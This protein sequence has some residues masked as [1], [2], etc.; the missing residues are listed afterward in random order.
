VVDSQIQP[1]TTSDA[2]PSKRDELLEAAE[3]LFSDRGFANT[4][5]SEIAAAAG[6]GISTFYRYFPTKDALLGARIAERF[7]QL[8]NE[9]TQARENIENRPAAEQVE[10]T[11]ETFGIGFDA[12]VERPRLTQMVFTSGFGSSKEVR[13]LVLGLQASAAADLE[14]VL[15]RV[16]AASGLRIPAKLALAQAAVGGLLHLAYA[17]ITEGRPKRDDAI[18]ALSSMLIGA[19]A[20]A[21]P[22]WANEAK[23]PGV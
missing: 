22:Q 4:R 8:R 17:H 16:E 10:V 2:A 23:E 18:H 6:T 15:S 21:N 3:E 5:I 1:G 12:L 13:D 9:L 14:Q 20:I 7:G 19:I 11:R